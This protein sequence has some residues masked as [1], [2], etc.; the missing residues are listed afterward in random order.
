MDIIEIRNKK[1]NRFLALKGVDF[2]VMR[3]EP[4]RASA[5]LYPNTERIRELIDEFFDNP[6]KWKWI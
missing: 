3:C 6:A 5:C 1:L 2:A 4:K